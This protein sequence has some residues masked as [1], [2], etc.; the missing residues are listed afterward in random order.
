MFSC[1][2]RVRDL[3]KVIGNELAT[4]KHKTILTGMDPS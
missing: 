4:R 1:K 3:Q 2:E